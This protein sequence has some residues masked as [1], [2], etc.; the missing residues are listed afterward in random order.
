M[1]TEKSSKKLLREYGILAGIIAGMFA[2][3]IVFVVL[4]RGEWQNGLKEKISEVLEE[5]E[6]GKWI[7][8]DYVGIN[9]PVSLSTAC[10]QVRERANGSK[11]YV[12]M[13]RIETIYG[14]FPAVFVYSGKNDA[15]FVGISGLHGRIREQILKGTNDEKINFWIKRIPDIVKNTEE[16]GTNE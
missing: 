14:P 3:L 4:S 12:L 8:G 15:R 9:A 1:D 6:P 11:G 7:M 2:V 10:F 16:A 5:E 13:L